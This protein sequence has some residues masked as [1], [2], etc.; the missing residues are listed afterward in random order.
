MAKK[1]QKFEMIFQVNVSSKRPNE[2]N[3]TLLL[4]SSQTQCSVYPNFGGTQSF[5]NL[6]ETQSS[7]DFGGYCSK[8]S[9]SVFLII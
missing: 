2:R 6:V 8:K 9:L 1:V 4:K 7:L 3:S 5:M